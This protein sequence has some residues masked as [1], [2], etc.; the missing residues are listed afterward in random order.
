MESALRHSA[1]HRV[2]VSLQRPY[3]GTLSMR[4]VV[5]IDHLPPNT[6]SCVK[7]ILSISLTISIL[8]DFSS[9]FSVQLL[10]V[11]SSDGQSSVEMW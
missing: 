11:C 10:T 5:L 1:W 8:A 6:F 9:L 2:L 4:L 7:V 3:K